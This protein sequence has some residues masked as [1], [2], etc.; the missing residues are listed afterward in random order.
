MKMNFPNNNFLKERARFVGERTRLAC[1]VRR[2]AG[3]I[4]R[5]T[6][7]LFHENVSRVRTS[8]RDADWSSRDGCA[9]HF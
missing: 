5:S 9:P 3:R 4:E 6:I 7:S 8:R 1:S 2:R